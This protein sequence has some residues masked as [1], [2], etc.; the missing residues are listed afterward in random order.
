MINAVKRHASHLNQRLSKYWI[1]LVSVHFIIIRATV[2]STIVYLNCAGQPVIGKFDIAYTS[3]LKAGLCAY[4]YSNVLTLDERDFTNWTIRIA[5][6]C[7]YSI[8]FIALRVWLLLHKGTRSRVT[9]ELGTLN[10]SAIEMALI[11]RKRWVLALV[12]MLCFTLTILFEVREGTPPKNLAV[13]EPQ[14]PQ[15]PHVT[16]EP[17]D[18]Q[19]PKAP[20]VPQELPARFVSKEGW[21]PTGSELQ[22]LHTKIHTDDPLE[23]VMLMIKTGASVLWQ[24]LPIHLFTT[25]SRF[26]HFGLYSDAPG[27]IGGIEV[28]DILSGVSNDT[29]STDFFLLYNRQKLLHDVHSNC[30]EAEVPLEVL[31]AGPYKRINGWSLDKFKNLPMIMHAYELNPNLD[32]YIFMDS[33]TYFV[34]D[35]LKSLLSKYNPREHLYFGKRLWYDAATF[36][37][38]LFAQGGSGVILS[39]KTMKEAYAKRDNLTFYEDWTVSEVGGDD[40]VAIFLEEELGVTVTHSPGFFEDSIHSAPIDEGDWCHPI[41]SF[42]HMKP[43]DIEIWWEYEQVRRATK[44]EPILVADY[45]VDFILPY[46]ADEVPNWDSKIGGTLFSKDSKVR[47]TKNSRRAYESI[48]ACKQA[49]IDTDSCKCWRFRTGPVQECRIS[50]EIRI[51]HSVFHW[52]KSAEMLFNYTSGWMI[53]RIR[54]MRARTSCDPPEQ[55]LNEGWFRSM[56]SMQQS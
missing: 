11:A 32:W 39:Q 43:R 56:Q 24:S 26:P 42:H 23:N 53:D 1:E 41:Y 8:P 20:Q 52:Q 54:Q 22:G 12:G 33:D 13:N 17:Q 19:E 18:P 10:N 21:R 46:I 31:D 14:E 48:A 4:S 16:K 35:N 9:S 50:N 45:Y 28:Y 2:L 3:Y 6:S 49:C 30:D 47:G 25:L 27:S 34:A 5:T 55:S 7:A 51:G 37:Q 44:N 38:Y 36:K 40:M 15:Q 29:R